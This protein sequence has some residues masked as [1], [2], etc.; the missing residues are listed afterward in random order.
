MG[1]LIGD[2]KRARLALIQVLKNFPEDRRNEILFDRWSLKDLLAH[3]SGWMIAA[4][5]NVK[6]LKK[7]NIPPWVESINDFNKNNVEKRK[8]WDWDQ[9]YQELVK[10][11]RKFIEKYEGLPKELW[12]KKYWP[13]RSFT[14]KKILE[15][16]VK[17]WRDTHLP[18]IT[19]LT[20]SKD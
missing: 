16:E 12:Q 9:V 2:F 14:P 17:H 15:I 18:Q 13:K 3:M 8:N 19:K 6:F 5:N 1:G 10:T 11:S 20:K 7:G 4:T